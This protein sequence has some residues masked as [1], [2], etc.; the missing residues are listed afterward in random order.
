MYPGWEIPA[1][2]TMACNDMIVVKLSPDLRPVLYGQLTSAV[3]AL[4]SGGP[5]R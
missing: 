4:T 2:E 1:D 3:P 5:E